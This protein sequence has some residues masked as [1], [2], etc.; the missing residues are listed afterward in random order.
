MADTNNI[1]EK[2]LK[3]YFRKIRRSLVC[4]WKTKNKILKDL[5]NDVEEYL[6]QNPISSFKN[7]T[8]HFGN[9][10]TI[11]EEFAISSGIDYVKKSRIHKALKMIVII[12]LILASIFTIATSIVIIGNNNR[13][14]VYYYEE[15]V[16][17]FGIIE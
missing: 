8:E 4:D 1:S 16:D 13:T 10:E 14:A 11:A 12:F 17:D 3:K 7:I 15:S 2:E 5:K 9:P 6:E